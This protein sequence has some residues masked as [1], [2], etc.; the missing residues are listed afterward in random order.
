MI[1]YPLLPLVDQAANLVGQLRIVLVGHAAAAPDQAQQ[2]LCR[3]QQFLIDL[4]CP[5]AA[6]EN[7]YPVNG[8]GIGLDGHFTGK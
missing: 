5:L 6:L 1:N 3:G 7:L 8:F 4:L 2:I